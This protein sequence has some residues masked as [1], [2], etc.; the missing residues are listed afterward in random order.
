MTGTIDFEASFKNEL[1][2]T[3][4]K[5]IIRESFLDVWICNHFKVLPTEHRFKELS[6]IQKHLLLVGYLESPTSEEMH[7]AYQ[8]QDAAGATITE[9]DEKDFKNIGYTEEQI[10]RMKQQLEAAGLA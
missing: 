4:L 8:Q 9:E 7:A 5:E 3:D 6:E 2:G 1:E 10:E